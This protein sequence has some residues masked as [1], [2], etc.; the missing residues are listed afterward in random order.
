MT[1]QDLRPPKHRT[2]A[3]Q[4]ASGGTTKWLLIALGIAAAGYG[5]WYARE[6][7]AA[8]NRATTEAPPVTAPT[9]AVAPPASSEPLQPAQPPAEEPASPEPEPQA[10][11][12]PLHPLSEA[13]TSTADGSDAAALD[14]WVVQWLGNQ[15]LQFVVTPGLAHHIVATVDNLSRGHAAPRLWPLAPVGGKMVLEEDAQGKRIAASNSTRY[16]A[17]VG[18]VTGIDP[19]QAAQW[20]RQA[21]PVL[22]QTYENLGYPGKYFNDRLVA[23]IDH[24][25]QTPP[26]QE[27]IALRLVQVQGQVAPQQP[28]L[29]YE[30]ADA[31]LQ[32]LSAGQ[33][34]LLRLG[35]DHRQRVA[36][37]LQAFRAQIAS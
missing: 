32:S 21:Y 7:W 23:V 26:V 19:T 37:Y 25:L 34:I 36:T 13:E 15:A 2:R 12:G 9:P 1:D 14:Q 20:Y 11:D 17:V 8:K 33:K 10:T 35:S 22:Q 3:D 18:F 27:P 5:G 24:L 6:H 16:D 31:R 4:G 29:R 28:W 30:F